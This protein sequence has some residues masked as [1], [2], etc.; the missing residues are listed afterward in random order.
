MSLAM[1]IMAAGKGTR[2]KSDLPKVLHQANGKPV[3]EYVVETSRSLS[4][5]HIVLIVGHQAERVRQATAHLPVRYALQEPQLGTG[6]AVMQAERPLGDFDGDV[7]ILSGDAPLVTPETLQELIASHRNQKATATVLTAEL[8]DPA[9]YGRVIRSP[10]TGDVLKIVEQKD[11][12]EEEKAV[13]EINSGVYVFDAAT[14]FDL[15]SRITN[16]NAQ[17]EYYLT[18][19]FGI[20]FREHR[21]ISAFSASDPDEIRGINTPEQ[22]REAEEILRKQR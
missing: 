21:K 2:M 4:P 18:D 20:C 14:L 5:E 10:A 22:L 17:Q 12:S 9:G 3:I 7:I 15:L 19:V 11:A 1:I 8:D 16:D 6:H 13:R